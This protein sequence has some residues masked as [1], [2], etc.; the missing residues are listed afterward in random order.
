MHKAGL[1]TVL[2]LTV[3]IIA[4]SAS[5]PMIAYCA[6]PA[7]AIAFW[8]NTLGVTAIAPFAAVRQRAELRELFGPAARR[9]LFG[10]VLAGVWLAAHFG[11]W[12]PSAKLTNVAMATALVN[13]T[14]V[15]TALLAVLRRVHVPVVTWV[16]I[17]VS[18]LGTALATVT[19]LHVSTHALLGDALALTGGFAAAVYTTIGERVRVSV[20][21]TAY[22]LVCYS[23]CAVALLG[24]SLVLGV[25][26]R[27]YTGITWI[28]IVAMTVGPQLLGHSLFNFSLRRV[29]ATTIAVLLLL[30]VPG[31]ALI[32]WILLGQLPA[33]RTLPGLILLLAGV[34]VVLV[35]ARR[36]DQPTKGGTAISPEA[37]ATT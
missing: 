30:E 15:W 23:V 31:A 4:I 22:T 35:G 29:S 12:I 6:A 9:T 21:T 1:P 5:A 34:A 18:V 3:A 13:T 19:D 16:G 8:R 25:H 26:L 10:C 2:A 17:G 11:T 27:G 37:I 14:P 32:G 24:V 33:A 7:L 36:G 20:S 28:L